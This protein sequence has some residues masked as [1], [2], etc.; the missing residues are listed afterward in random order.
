MFLAFGLVAE[1]GGFERISFPFRA[2]YDARPCIYPNLRESDWNR[3]WSKSAHLDAILIFAGN[4]SPFSS[5]PYFQSV[6]VARPFGI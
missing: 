6:F 2:F 5:S 3:S 1:F 4:A